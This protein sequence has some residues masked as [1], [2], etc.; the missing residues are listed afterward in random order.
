VKMVLISSGPGTPSR[1]PAPHRVRCEQLH[2]L[3]ER[4]L[5]HWRCRRPG[6][7]LSLADELP[8]FHAGR[9]RTGR[10]AVSGAP[11]CRPAPPLSPEA[12]AMRQILGIGRLVSMAFCSRA[13][14]G[15]GCGHCLYRLVAMDLLWAR[16]GGTGRSCRRVRRWHSQ[17][18]DRHRLEDQTGSFAGLRRCCPPREEEAFGPLGPAR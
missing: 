3:I 16:V 12:A 10:D 5:S 4:P 17:L 1:R 2:H 8:L 7:M 18:V 11:S 15:S 13:S 14:P 9:L 6:P